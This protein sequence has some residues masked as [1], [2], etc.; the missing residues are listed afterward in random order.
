MSI[1]ISKDSLSLN[2]FLDVNNIY[3][4]PNQDYYYLRDTL[5]LFKLNQQDFLPD[6][7]IL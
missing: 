5:N 4:S 3:A 2:D 7:A 1:P 6:L